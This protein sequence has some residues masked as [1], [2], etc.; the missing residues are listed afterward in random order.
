MN[1]LLKTLFIVSALISFLI[2]LLF[3]LSL[4]V[5]LSSGGNV[6]FPGLGL[7]VA[8]GAIVILLLMMLLIS[9]VITFLLYKITFRNSASNS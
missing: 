3:V 5:W 2:L 6:L 9:F 7:I 8:M 4:I 1:F